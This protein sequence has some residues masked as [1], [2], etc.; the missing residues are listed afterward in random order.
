VS[1]RQAFPLESGTVP[2][3]FR[4]EEP[5]AALSTR[6]AA[7]AKRPAE[8]LFYEV[9][10]DG[11]FPNNER[12]PVVVYRAAFQGSPRLDPSVLER[13]FYENDW[14]NGWRNGVYDFHHFHSVAHE[15]LG[16]YSGSARLELGGPG[17]LVLDL[18]TGDVVVLPAGV[19][20]RKLEASS[21]FKVVGCYAGGLDYDMNRED[22]DPELVRANI[23]RTPLPARDPVYGEWGPLIQRWQGSK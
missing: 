9:H 22:A 1:A 6:D 14:S 4:E 19:S 23:E 11:P 3:K 5:M 13:V 17:G 18:S 10:A 15:V 8:I 21:D 16:C 20:H 7:P 12:L 2:A